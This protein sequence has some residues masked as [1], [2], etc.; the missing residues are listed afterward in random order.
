MSYQKQ[1]ELN[2]AYY[3]PSIP[4]QPR[5]YNRPGRRG[6]GGC[7]CCLFDCLCNCI[8]SCICTI[9]CTIL[10]I[11]G[12]AVL[13]FWL[14]VRPH[15]IKFYASDASLTTFN[16][17]QNDNLNYNLAV[18]FTIRNPNRH[19]GVY[20]DKIEANAIYETQRFSTVEAPVFYQ[21]K[22]NTTDFGPVVFKGNHL[23]NL[24]SED[25]A[26]YK[27]QSDDGV[28]EIQI[29][30]Y[31][32]VRFKLGLYKT[33]TWKPKIKCDL[34]VPLEGKSSSSSHVFEKTKCHYD[35]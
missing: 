3:G 12:L 20:Y 9:L 31:L 5:S 13:I 4:P 10:V 17:T 34:K 8:M 21:G 6:G 32:R 29:K 16:F 35:I 1:P 24:G 28:Y 26:D 14:I 7:G 33:G 22:K 25:K 2:G 15:E 18:N 27:K 23:V 11:L 30:V 19:I